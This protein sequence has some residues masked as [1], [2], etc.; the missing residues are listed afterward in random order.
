MYNQRVVYALHDQNQIKLTHKDAILKEQARFYSDLYES[1]QNELR[2]PPNYLENLFLPTLN[3][4]GKASLDDPIVHEEIV[5][6]IR[7][8]NNNK[9][10]GSDGIPVEIY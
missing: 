5:E 7:A 9:V 8:L 3:E 6:P 1:R 4:V 2:S 10:S